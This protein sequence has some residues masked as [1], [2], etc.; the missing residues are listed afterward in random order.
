[1]FTKG[2]NKWNNVFMTQDE[3]VD[4]VKGTIQSI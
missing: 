3:I 4:S 2:N 1:M